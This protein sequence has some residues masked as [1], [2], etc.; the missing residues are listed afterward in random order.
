[1][2][3]LQGLC[4]TCCNIKNAKFLIMFLV[5][6]LLVQQAIFAEETPEEILKKLEKIPLP[7]EIIN[8]RGMMIEALT[9]YIK[10][11]IKQTAQFH[12]KFPDH[13]RGPELA[14]REIS[15][16]TQIR[17]HSPSVLWQEHIEL[18]KKQYPQVAAQSKVLLNEEFLDLKNEL[19]RVQKHSKEEFQ[20]ARRKAFDWAIANS[21]FEPTKDFAY[22]VAVRMGTDDPREQREKWFEEFR[23][24][25]PNDPRS[26]SRPNFEPEVEIGQLLRLQFEGLNGKTID[27]ADFKGKVV[28]VDFWATWCAPCLQA[29]KVLKKL[30]GE[31]S[32]TGSLEI[33][34]VSTDRKKEDLEKFLTKDPYP[35]TVVWDGQDKYSS[36]W[37]FTG[38]PYYLIVDQ[39]GILR[40]KGNTGQLQTEILE[41][42]DPNS[43]FLL[44]ED[45]LK[46]LASNGASA[47]KMFE[48]LNSAKY[49]EYRVAV[50][51]AGPKAAIDL[52][53]QRR[54]AYAA[55]INDLAWLFLERYPDDPRITEVLRAWVWS[56]S[57][58]LLAT[59]EHIGAKI[60]KHGGTDVGRQI[61][62]LQK[63]YAPLLPREVELAALIHR[64]RV[65]KQDGK[66]NEL[67]GEVIRRLLSFCETK[68]DDILNV[69]AFFGV[70]KQLRNE[71]KDD[72]ALECPVPLRLFATD[73]YGREI[74]TNRWKGK[75]VLVYYGG[76]PQQHLPMLRQLWRQYHNQGIEIV[77]INIDEDKANIET[78]IKT[79]GT[80]F[81]SSEIKK[82]ESIP[83]PVVMKKRQFSDWYLSWNY[84]ST[85]NL[86]VLDRKGR[87]RH[88]S[89]G[90]RN[91]AV[92]LGDKWYVIANS[93]VPEVIESLLSK[94]PSKKN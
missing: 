58:K 6:L 64:A 81:E 33:I 88:T 89:T 80:P 70:M 26:Q 18:L 19:F 32:D 75:V 27:T 2:F 84:I 36:C 92:R 1:M 13:R 85:P 28:V 38:I 53:L 30:Y 90:Y 37:K 47:D 7:D 41:Y 59:N 56:A 63:R 16:I 66:I 62:M 78:Y 79:G 91:W 39:K 72:P 68:P 42:L 10:T 25:F 11:Y 15:M 9:D 34:G 73:F 82:E 54:A 44:S 50:K 46:P 60:I 35:W 40:F 76:Y 51:D 74:D 12:E 69:P 57:D 94:S 3:K 87:I 48:T 52:F 24:A 31:Y 43:T 5:V 86:C 17:R 83:W 8:D 14:E 61:E 21:N 49:S 29:G 55:K 77:E 71:D 93:E 4:N 45:E 22:L 65:I 23:Q 67:G 20:K